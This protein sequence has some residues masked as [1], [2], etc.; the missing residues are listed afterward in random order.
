MSVIVVAVVVMARV[1]EMMA[2]VVDVVVVGHIS[3][4][5]LQSGTSSC[6]GHGFPAPVVSRVTSMVLSDPASHCAVH[7]VYLYSQSNINV[8]VVTVVV[9]T[10]VVVKLV[11][12]VV[13]VVVVVSTRGPKRNPT[14]TG[15]GYSLVT[16]PTVRVIG[17]RAWRIAGSGLVSVE[18]TVVV[19]MVL[20]AARGCLHASPCAFGLGAVAVV[21]LGTVKPSGPVAV[22]SVTSPVAG[23]STI[24]ME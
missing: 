23:V 4:P 1:V 14:K 9:E 10:V 6:T 18:L 21:P 20:V 24:G 15:P 11:V 16:P 5:G 22:V 7:V 12:V 2:V 17:D 3:S 13:A 8:V 19:D